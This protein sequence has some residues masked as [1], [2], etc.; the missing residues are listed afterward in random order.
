LFSREKTYQERRDIGLQPIT[1][2]AVDGFVP[3]S[4]AYANG[5]TP[6]MM[7]IG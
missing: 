4:M 7:S 1:K 2:P 6:F 3:C 5:M